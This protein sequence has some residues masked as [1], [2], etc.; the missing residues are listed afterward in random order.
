VRSETERRDFAWA[1][2]D[3][4][5]GFGIYD[6]KAEVWREDLLKALIP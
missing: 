3:F 6:P 4:A 2:W 1:Y 5:A